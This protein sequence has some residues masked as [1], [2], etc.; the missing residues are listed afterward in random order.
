MT[1]YADVLILVN[2][3]VD[4]FLILLSSKFL[5]I[6]TKFLRLI[7]SALT[8]GVFSLYMLLPQTE[9]W[10]QIL[11]N[12]LMCAA[13]CAIAYGFKDIKQFFK[14]VA[15]L[16]C[17]NFAYSGA[18]IA[19]WLLFKPY[20]MVINNSVVYFNI[21]PIF[22]IIFSVLGY[23]IATLL[24]K[25]LKDKFAQKIY[26]QVYVYFR[27]N[28]LQ[29]T[30]I[31]DTGNTLRDVFGMCEIFITQAEV[32]DTLL[33]E[34]KNNPA[35]FRKIPCNTVAGEKLLDGYRIDRA[36]VQCEKNKYVFEKVV[37]AVSQT[38]LTDCEIIINPEILN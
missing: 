35:R 25:V 19:I 10:F 33:G 14:N 20:G 6:K 26:C 28:V 18:M 9:Y 24:H 13:L 27:N 34:E 31:A 37:L 7:L 38:K 29:L 11:I 22:L 12:I 4:Y 36:V 21:S 15:V 3:I 17:V 32:I 23:F 8:G 5:H 1:V 2:F 30:G 16:F